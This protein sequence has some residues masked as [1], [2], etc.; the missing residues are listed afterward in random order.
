[1]ACALYE[2]A[3][4]KYEAV[5]EV[6]PRNRPILRNCAFAMYDL[7]RLQP[8]PASRAAQQLLEVSSIAAIPTVLDWETSIAYTCMD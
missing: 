2:A 3:V 4:A 8:N 5:L 1:M 7:G 6:D